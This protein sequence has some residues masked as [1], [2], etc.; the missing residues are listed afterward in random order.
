MNVILDIRD[1]C[2]ACPY[3]DLAVTCPSAMFADG[4]IVSRSDAKV[5]CRHEEL[6][7]WVV[8]RS[9][10]LNRRENRPSQRRN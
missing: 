9:G 1:Y 6:C 7:K 5:Y 2:E 4:E 8:K 3:M 10:Y